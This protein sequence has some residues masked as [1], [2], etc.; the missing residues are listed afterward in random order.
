MQTG[1]L[2]WDLTSGPHCNIV[3]NLVVIC[4][5]VRLV[6]AAVVMD[7]VAS[8]L[9]IYS[10]PSYMFLVDW[11]SIACAAFALGCAGPV[12][13]TSN[14]WQME[15]KSWP[16]LLIHVI[17]QS[18]PLAQAWSEWRKDRPNR[19]WKQT[20]IIFPTPCGLILF[21]FKLQKMSFSVS[22]RRCCLVTLMCPFLWNLP[23][24]PLCCSSSSS[25]LLE[26]WLSSKNAVEEK[27]SFFLLGS[28]T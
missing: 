19:R 3:L 15:G 9:S 16:P 10:L 22:L 17:S 27:L 1:A 6:Y 26:C 18:K 25:S 2:A 8:P 4:P 28:S 24:F 20:L 14:L 5:S 13:A 7:P 11:H 12:Q 23:G 21:P